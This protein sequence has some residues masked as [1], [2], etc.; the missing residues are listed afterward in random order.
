VAFFV[1]F[2]P[3]LQSFVFNLSSPIPFLRNL[4]RFKTIQIMNKQQSIPNPTTASKSFLTKHPVA[5]TILVG[6]LL[7]A[8]V[9]VW[10]DW[11]AKKNERQLTKQAA[12]QIEQT[13]VSML[14]LLSKPLVWNIRSELLRGNNEQIDIL[15]SDM[16]REQNFQYIHLVEPD[17]N[18]LLSTN[19]RL[20]GQPMGDGLALEML[21][22]E[23]T[24]VQLIDSLYWVAS[25]VMGVD[26][27]LATL[28]FTYKN[29]PFLPRSNKQE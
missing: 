4:K 10:R 18:V 5:S 20:Q 23:Q 7:I 17:G 16:V 21:N 14:T 6:I 24:T 2:A 11:T 3:N 29:T 15:M 28:V 13:N 8:I 9:F 22:V 25:P 19:K 26:R 27:K 1:P 12:E